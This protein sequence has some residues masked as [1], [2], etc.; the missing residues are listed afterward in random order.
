MVQYIHQRTYALS[1]KGG[2]YIKASLQIKNGIY[3][4]VMYSN[5]K[6]RWRS[7]GIKAVRG[8]K[9]KAEERM[10]EILAEYDSNPGMFEKVPLSDYICKWLK[11]VKNQVDTVTYTGYKQYAEKHIIPYFKDLGLNLQDVRLSDIEGY[12][13]YKALSGRL[14]GKSGGL[15]YSSI[16]KHSVVLNQVFTEAVRNRLIQ[17]NPCELAKI[18]K[19]AA[20]SENAAS[21]YT[22]EQCEKLLAVTEGTILHDMIY[23][24]FMY[25]FR[26]SELMGLKWDAI[27]FD[28]NTLRVS[29]TVV[30]NSEIVK[31]DSTKTK[32]SNRVYPL[33][34]ETRAILLRLKQQQAEYRKFFGN[35][36]HETGYVFVHED[37]REYYPSYP[38][39]ELSKALKKH[40]LPHIRYHD[41]RHSCASM[42]LL[43]GWNMKDISEWLGH[44]NIG[45]TMD[46]YTH[47]DMAHKQ[48]L[49]K[50]FNGLFDK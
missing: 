10:K 24:T 46:L 30:L 32:S 42:L 44:S 16:K 26:R 19:T 5:S 25:G 14:D 11:T 13:S 45:I 38:T 15:S 9:R 41:L 47:I 29:H 35:T 37:G 28:N 18:P 2:I 50:S 23:L 17:R 34:P 49:G 40:N 33:I 7:T 20:K 1:T 43:R 3:Q 39:H 27:D 21:F 6:Y 36:Y 22:T 4:V 8:N 31:K 48:D 12:Y